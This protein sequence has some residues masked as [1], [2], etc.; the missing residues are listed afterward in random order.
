MVTSFERLQHI[1]KY[2][3]NKEYILWYNKKYDKLNMFKV[4]EYYINKSM[5]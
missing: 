3:R 2:N 5:V 1:V 4:S